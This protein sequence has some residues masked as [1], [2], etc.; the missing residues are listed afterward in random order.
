MKKKLIKK[1]K[2]KRNIKYILYILLFILI[3]TIFI[4]YTYIRYKDIESNKIIIVDQTEQQ[5]RK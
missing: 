4:I 1:Y 5:E 2:L 3:F